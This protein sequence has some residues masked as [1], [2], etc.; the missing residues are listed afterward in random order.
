MSICVR[1]RIV[2]GDGGWKRQ[3]D[4]SCPV[5]DVGLVAIWKPPNWCFAWSNSSTSAIRNALLLTSAVGFCQPNP[6][7]DRF[8]SV[9]R[10]VSL[11]DDEEFERPRQ[12]SPILGIFFWCFCFENYLKLITSE[13]C[14]EGYLILTFCIILLRLWLN[15]GSLGAPDTGH[16]L[17]S[18]VRP[19]DLKGDM[20]AGL[21]FRQAVLFGFMKP[22]KSESTF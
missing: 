10:T 3:K 19:L 13:P 1:F 22:N 5:P 4:G 16:P 8:S 14:Y 7:W 15:P 12:K 21:A 9:P 20:G 6:F 11:P 2:V 17:Q 18:W